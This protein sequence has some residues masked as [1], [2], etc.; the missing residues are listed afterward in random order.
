MQDRELDE[1]SGTIRDLG[2]LY[3]ESQ[4][5]T[6]SSNKD[7]IGEKETWLSIIPI[8]TSWVN[9]GAITGC[10]NWAPAT[11]T[12]EA[13]QS[14]TQTATDC[15]QAQ[16]RSK[17]EREQEITTNAIR[18]VGPPISEFKNI[19]VSSTKSATGTMVMKE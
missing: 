17:Q 7:A 6:V 18:D 12:V 16:T 9:S 2:E 5:I 1:I 8:Y 13:G 10:S 14:F 4:V 15:T 3:Y 19:T 11:S